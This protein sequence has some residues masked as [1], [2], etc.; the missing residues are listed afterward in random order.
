M[1]YSRNPAVFYDF[2]EIYPVMQIKHPEAQDKKKEKEDV[3]HQYIRI[4]IL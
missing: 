3:A 2:D 4:R 1:E